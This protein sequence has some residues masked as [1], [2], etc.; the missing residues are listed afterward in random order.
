MPISERAVELTHR[1]H[2]RQP[3]GRPHDH[4]QVDIRSELRRPG[5]H[6]ASSR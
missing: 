6:D 5:R 3:K 1:W 2:E 4:R